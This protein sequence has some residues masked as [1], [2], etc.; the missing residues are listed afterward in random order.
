MELCEKYE[1]G[2]LIRFDSTW[3]L[4]NKHQAFNWIDTKVIIEELEGLKTREEQV[5]LLKELAKL[6]ELPD[7]GDVPLSLKSE[8]RKFYPKLEEVA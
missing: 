7:F 1:A 3:V 5:R 6:A 8:Y 4:L 2:F